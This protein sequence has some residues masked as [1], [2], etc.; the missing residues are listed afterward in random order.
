MHNKFFLIGSIIFL[1]IN[2][3]FTQDV[4]PESFTEVATV[5]SVSKAKLYD[6]AKTW[7]LKKFMT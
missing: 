1:S 6:A 7:V 5:D 4:V 3:A 2:F